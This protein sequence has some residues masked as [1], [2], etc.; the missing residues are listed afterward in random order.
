M[1]STLFCVA[2]ACATC[3]RAAAPEV[4]EV[5][6][7]LLVAGG[8]ATLGCALAASFLDALHLELPSTI[9]RLVGLM[10]A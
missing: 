5:P 7:E 2:I 6:R 9:L 1:D 4:A 8:F 3:A 10:L